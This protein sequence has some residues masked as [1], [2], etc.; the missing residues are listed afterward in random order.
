MDRLSYVLALG[1]KHAAETRGYIPYSAVQRQLNA[2]N[3]EASAQHNKGILASAG[4][5]KKKQL[6]TIMQ[7]YKETATWSDGFEYAYWRGDYPMH[8]AQ[9]PM[10]VARFHA[11]NIAFNLLG[12]YEVDP[13]EFI[14]ASYKL[15]WD[16]KGYRGNGSILDIFW[17]KKGAAA[18]AFF[19]M[20]YNDKKRMP[21][22][23][24]KFPG[25]VDDVLQAVKRG[26]ALPMMWADDGMELLSEFVANFKY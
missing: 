17:Y 10:L 21:H 13:A 1:E 15:Y 4:I 25:G 20:V 5:S 12:G 18:R 26:E 3:L 6:R 16:A 23:Q 7:E 14:L 9:F 8:V 24:E 11:D 2:K 19:E 22:W